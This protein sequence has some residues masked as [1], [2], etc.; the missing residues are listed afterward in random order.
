MPLLFSLGIH[1]S[2]CAVSERLRPEDKVFGYLGGVHVAS[3]PD[4]TRGAF[5]LLGEKLSG[6]AVIQLHTGQTRVW[7]RG[8]TC[9]PDVVD[10]GEEVW[11]PAGIKILGT[12]IGSPEFVHR[13]VQQ[14]LEDVGGHRAGPR[15]PIR[16]ADPLAVC[17]VSLPSPSSDTPSESGN[18]ARSRT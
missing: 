8:G 2:L 14:R 17:R 10:L 12:P 7:N 18:G 6:G 9:P 4:R 1:D 11:N 13:T 3:P 16:V 15:S 5:N